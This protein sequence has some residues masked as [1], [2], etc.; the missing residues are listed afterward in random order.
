MIAPS[1]VLIERDSGLSLVERQRWASSFTR[2]LIEDFAPLW[3]MLA[4][5]RA[6]TPDEPL[7]DDEWPHYLHDQPSLTDPADAF[8]YHDRL[9]DGRPV[10]HT[11]VGLANQFN[12]SPSQ[13]ADHENKEA[14]ADAE[15]NDAKQDASGVFWATEVCD[16]CESIGYQ[17]DGIWV[18]DFVTPEWFSPRADGKSKQF[19][20]LNTIRNA[21]G[22]LPGGY[23]QKFL[24]G[25][26]WHTVGEQSEYRREIGRL[27]LG[28][29]ARRNA[30]W[31]VS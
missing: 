2:T 20:F 13:S 18:S 5:C 22:V 11:F 17:K 30:I 29:G 15:L 25:I 31:V 12:A 14:L 1:I 16:P 27:L 7:R 9:P 3:G 24:D 4:S 23:A 21:F 26:G 19:N 28:R 6:E 10:M 8:A